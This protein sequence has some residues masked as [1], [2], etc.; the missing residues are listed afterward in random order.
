M[1]WITNFVRPASRALMRKHRRTPD[2]LWRKCPACGEMIF[3]RD[4]EANLQC[5][6]ALR[7]S[8]AHR[9]AKTRFA[10]AVRRR[11]L[12]SCIEL[13]EV[14]ADPLQVPRRQAL[15][16]PASRKPAPRPAQQDALVA[17]RGTLDGMPVMIAVQTSTSWAARSA[18]R[19]AT[20]LV[21]AQAAVQRTRAV[22]PDRRLRR[23]AHAGRHPLADADAAH[24]HR[25]RRC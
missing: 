11:R 18:W 4:L 14:A 12:S 16:R 20:A 15:C 6:P 17:A 23:R 1:N 8:H 2:N 7:P 24:H 9:R 22:H 13:P 21:A 10:H 3:H 5:L 19:S 25:R